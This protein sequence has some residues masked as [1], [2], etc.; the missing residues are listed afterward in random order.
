MT[1]N[2]TLNNQLLD[3]LT[4]FIKFFNKYKLIIYII[5]MLFLYSFLILKI[6]NLDQV[7]FSANSKTNN[8]VAPAHINQA[9]INQLQQLQNNNVNVKALFEQARNNPF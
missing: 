2:T 5:F 9:I 8:T 4:T 3:S 6:N 1:K 7:S